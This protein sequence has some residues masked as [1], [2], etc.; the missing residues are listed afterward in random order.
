MKYMR[1]KYIIFSK[2]N[3]KIWYHFCEKACKRYRERD[4]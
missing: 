2:Q 4:I 3:Y 1:C